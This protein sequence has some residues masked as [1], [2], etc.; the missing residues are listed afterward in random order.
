MT[1]LAVYIAAAVAEIV[2][3]YAFWAVVRLGAPTYWL[4][5]G[6]ASLIAFGWLLTLVDVA[7]AG[8]AYAVYG[9]IYIAMSLAFLWGVERQVPDRWDA[10][11]AVV[12]VL[13]ALI[14]LYG[15]RTA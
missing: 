2:G 8:R 12:C 4:A 10:I 5:P 14:I 7:A 1:T 9:G 6:A 15:P 3:C 11:G 13:G